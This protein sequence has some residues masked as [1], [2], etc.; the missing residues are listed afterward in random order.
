MENTAREQEREGVRIEKGTNYGQQGLAGV[1]RER[2]ARGQ[3][4]RSAD[5]VCG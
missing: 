4:L 1:R 2:A 5:V 3:W